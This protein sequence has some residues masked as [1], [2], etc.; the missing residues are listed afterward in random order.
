MPVGLGFRY[1]GDVEKEE[2]RYEGEKGG[3]DV[4]AC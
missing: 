2:A 1:Q 3:V 4:E